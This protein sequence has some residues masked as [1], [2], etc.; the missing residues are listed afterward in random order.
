MSH[1]RSQ[2]RWPAVIE[3]RVALLDRLARRIALRMGRALT[4]GE[5]TVFEGEERL[6]FG[7]RKE[8]DLAVTLRI[9]DSRFYRELVLGGTLGLGKACLMG[10]WSADDLA[11][12]LFLRNRRALERIEGGW[13]RL[14]APFARLYHLLRRNT[15]AGSRR[16]ST[17]LYDLGNDFFALFLDPTW[18]YSCAFFESE[19]AT[20][21]EASTAKNERVCRKLELS[22]A[23]HVLEIGSGWGGFACTPPRVMA[24]GS[25]PPPFPATRINWP[26]SA[27]SAP[28]SATGSRCSTATIGSS[29]ASTT[30]SCP[31]R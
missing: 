21:E 16:N 30:S 11:V 26:A 9:H 27:S 1:S 28:A 19:R 18:S 13:A 24:A 4:E 31:S 2:S 3:P 17:A 22:P 12:R 7:R 25:R 23:D 8:G 20:L 6:V 10:Y 14:T 5:L 29:A 15:P